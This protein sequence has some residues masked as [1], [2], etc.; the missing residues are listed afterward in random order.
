MM[1][2]PR[3]ALLSG[4]AVLSAV[5]FSPKAQAQNADIDFTGTIA[6]SC[7][8]NSATNGELEPLGPNQL[9]ADP[10]FSG[11]AGNVNVTCDNGTTFTVT[12][13]AN[14][15]GSVFNDIQR[16][17][18]RVKD[19]NTQIAVGEVS[20]TGASVASPVGVAGPVQTGPIAAKDYGVTL[21]VNNFA[22][23]LPAGTY[24]IRVN[25]ALTPQ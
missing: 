2:F 14:N 4:F 11:T 20:P 1:N 22:T 16:I 19:G 24:N 8:I 18:A 21:H 25:V 7:D 3:L 13:I 10:D 6:V 9:F 15:G 5:A 23:A 12:S 17:T